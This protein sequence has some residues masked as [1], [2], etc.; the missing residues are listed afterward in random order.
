MTAALLRIASPETTTWAKGMLSADSP[1]R[2]DVTKTG[3]S[4]SGWAWR[5]AEAASKRP[6]QVRRNR[7]QTR[8]RGFAR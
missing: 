5:P 4:D 1:V 6:K 7:M 8:E 2:A 3:S